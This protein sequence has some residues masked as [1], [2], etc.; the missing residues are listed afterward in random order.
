MDIEAKYD[1]L[2]PYWRGHEVSLST[3]RAIALDFLPIPAMSAEVERV[4]SRYLTTANGVLIEAQNKRSP[5]E[6][7]R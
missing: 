7:A 3:W 5:I 2:Y 6:G 1:C 4:F